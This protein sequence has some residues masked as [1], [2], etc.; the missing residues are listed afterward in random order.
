MKHRCDL[1]ARTASR[2]RRWKVGIVMASLA[3]GSLAITPSA[4][5][6][7]FCDLFVSDHGVNIDFTQPVSQIRTSANQVSSILTQVRKALAPDTPKSVRAFYAELAPLVAQATDV[8][9]KTAAHRLATRFAALSAS[10]AGKATGVWISN[11]CPTLPD[12][13]ILLPTA[14]RKPGNTATTG[15]TF[16]S[17]IP[18][19]TQGASARTI[20]PC[21]LVI[22]REAATAL[23]SDP[24]PPTRPNSRECVYGPGFGDTTVPTLWAAVVPTGGK[25]VFAVG[26]AYRAPE[27]EAFFEV[28][29]GIGDAAFESGKTGD[30]GDIAT[31]TFL[32]GDTMVVVTVLSPA[33]TA[34][35]N[36]ISPARKAASR[37]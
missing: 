10:P 8:R 20:D 37:V 14:P 4:H 24:G 22:E 35:N 28:V 27:K 15:N 18:A 32:K 17:T 33:G 31:L 36:V 3:F 21:S 9:T 26:S 6:D 11:L 19:P 30:Q 25:A 2:R 34:R 23:G 29:S 5:A 16:T 12:G 13:D 7:P 1:V